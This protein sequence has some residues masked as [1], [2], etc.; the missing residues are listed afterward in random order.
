MKKMLPLIAFLPMLAMAQ[1]NTDSIL[2]KHISDETMRNGKAYEWLRQLTKSVGGRLA[3][4]PQFAKAIAWGKKAMDSIGADKVYLQECKVPH[5]VRGQ[6]DKVA[7]TAINGKPSPTTL[8]ALALGNTIG[9]GSKGVTAE[10]LAVKD[11]AQLEQLKDKVKGKI[12]FYNYPFNP[13]NIATFL[14]Y[15]DAGKYR[16][17]GASRAAK[18]GAVGM[19]VRSMSESTDNNPHTGAQEYNDSFPKIPAAAIGLQDADRLWQQ[20]AASTV[21]IKMVTHGHFL[22][23]TTAYNVIAEIT[24]MDLPNEIIT[25]GG[26]LD[27]W[28]VN[29]GA[30]D[31][32]AGVVHTMEVLRVL[33][34]VGYHPKHTIRFVLFANE[35]NGSKGAEKYAEAAKEKNEQ[36]IFALESDAGGFTPRGF[37]FGV[38]AQAWGKLNAWKTLF[39]PYGG[40]SFTV[41]GGGEDT[42]AL[43]AAFKTPVAEL[44]PD[45]QRYF[46]VHHARSDVFENVNRRELL[47]GAVNMAALIYLV[48]NYGL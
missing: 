40:S 8:D 12:V 44:I 34:A 6:N 35:E 3:G 20:C 19:I 39:E 42:E 28:D 25:V 43:K 33:K 30:H 38:P 37:S 46:D 16:W 17:T 11:F 45:S 48:D 26:H 14:S 9:S 29:E 24:G 13:T 5:W 41:G 7:I 21:T 1:T 36:H 10:V 23:D 22:P 4:S 15:A 32:G 27:S 31:D 47:L 2:I 18:Y